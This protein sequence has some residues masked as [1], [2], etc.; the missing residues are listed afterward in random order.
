MDF[1]DVGKEALS[2]GVVLAIVA[3]IALFVGADR[4]FLR[5]LVGEW[6]WWVGIL[7]LIVIL[8]GGWRAMRRRRTPP[9]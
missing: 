7:V 6:L 5:D 4:G 1:K 9:S 8:F 2:I 3:V